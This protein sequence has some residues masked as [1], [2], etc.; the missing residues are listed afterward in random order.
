[1]QQ[2]VN[3]YAIVVA[4]IDND[5]P[6]LLDEIQGVLLGYQQGAAFH[7]LEYVSGANL[8]GVGTMQLWREIYSDY[9]YMRET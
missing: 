9:E 6:A 1:M 7:D 8:G 5:M 3:Q 2:V 4:T